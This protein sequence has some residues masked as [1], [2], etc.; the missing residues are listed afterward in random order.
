MEEVGG[1]KGESEGVLIAMKKRRRVYD[2]A[3]AEVTL[4]KWENRW[5]V[6]ISS[7]TES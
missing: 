7:Q 1:W 6:G 4:R 3:P 5:K 2:I